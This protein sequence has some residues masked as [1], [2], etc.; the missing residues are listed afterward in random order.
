MVARARL[1]SLTGVRF[2]AALTVLLGHSTVVTGQRWNWFMNFGGTAVSCFFVL[3]GMVLAWSCLGMGAREF[4]R[5]RVARIYPTYLVALVFAW[6]VTSWLGWSTQWRSWIA[7][8]TLTQCWFPHA[9]Q[10]TAM[11]TPAWS[12]SDEAFFYLCFPLLAALVA[13]M[14][15]PGRQW[16]AL[17]CFGWT[18]AMTWLLISHSAQNGNSTYWLCYMFPPS[19]MPEFVL[20]II[21]ALELRDGLRVPG[22][23]PLGAFGL[24]LIVRFEVLGT[25]WTEPYTP[26]VVLGLLWLGSRDLLD[27]RSFL[28]SPA[29][30]ALGAWSYAMYLFHFPLYQAALES[31][32]KLTFVLNGHGGYRQSPE[33]VFLIGHRWVLVVLAIVLTVVLCRELYVYFEAPLERRFKRS[34]RSRD[35]GLRQAKAL[36][37]VPLVRETSD[38]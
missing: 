24:A 10:L 11:L 36:K 8:V 26:F 31:A 27:A 5:R 33:A 30:L 7:M 20:G 37:P 6:L 13:R 22:W 12:L 15:R 19:R 38:S 28:R 9:S 18:I 32:E 3:S 1:D 4:Y 35:P 14:S 21:A 16:L 25:S 23:A 29:M 34:L 17:G 2:L